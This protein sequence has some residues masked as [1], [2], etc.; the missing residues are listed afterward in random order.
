MQIGYVLL[1]IALAELFLGLRFLFTYHK[2][3]SVI[4][5]GLFCIGVAIYV[6]ANGIG[7]LTE[8]AYYGERLS[9]VGGMMATT[10]FLPFTFVFPLPR[11]QVSE[12]IGWVVWPLLVFIPG[13]LLT[14]AFVN[15]RGIT[16]FG[17]SYQTSTGELFW[18]MI[19]AFLC[20]WVW[21]L[22]NLIAS[23]RASDG[24]HRRNLRLILTGIIVSIIF[25]IIFDILIPLV[26][27]SSVGYVGS[28]MTSAWLGVTTYIIRKH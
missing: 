14:N 20:Y 11:R 23:F 24:I 13:L 6:G 2:Q 8:S 19:G 9:W 1:A 12:T 16:R 7:F 17:Q 22:R 27:K 10:F 5:Y 26:T 4:W 18:L 15:E 21:S 28:L 25:A 3:Q